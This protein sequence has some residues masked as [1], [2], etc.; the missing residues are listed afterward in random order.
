M[1]TLA[2]RSMSSR[3]TSVCPAT[4]AESSGVVPSSLLESTALRASSKKR[5]TSSRPPFAALS[6]GEMPKALVDALMAST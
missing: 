5:T 6:S 3:H 2:R 4:T 1:P